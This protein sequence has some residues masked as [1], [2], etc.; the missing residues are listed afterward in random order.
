MNPC[1]ANLNFLFRNIDLACE[2][3]SRLI[4]YFLDT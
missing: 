1:I 2:R 4:M 3:R